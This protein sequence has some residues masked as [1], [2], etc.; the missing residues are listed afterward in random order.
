M[1][2][3]KGGV[4]S[5]CGYIKKVGERTFVGENLLDKFN[6]ASGWMDVFSG[7][8]KSGVDRRKRREKHK[9]EGKSSKR[10][11]SGGEKRGRK[12]KK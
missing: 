1:L 3:G 2:G 7:E 11:K 9:R 12:K 6:D 5:S 10:K 4:K 8:K